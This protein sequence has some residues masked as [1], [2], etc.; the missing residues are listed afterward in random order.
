[1]QPDP[2]LHLTSEWLRRG[3]QD[4]AVADQF[5]RDPAFC[6]TVAFHAQQAVEKSL[7][8]YLT[9]RNVP[10]RQTH[11]LEGLAA[12]CAQVDPA[13]IPLVAKVAPLT[14]YVSA[15]RYPFTP[16]TVTLDMALEALRTAHEL[17][18]FVLV[19]LPP[20]VQAP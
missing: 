4:L 16:V 11:I 8:A 12:E 15:G 5:S 3:H 19:H 9:W 18:A 2:R 20:E 1:M 10:F 17:C 13:F 14:P 6:E 7:K